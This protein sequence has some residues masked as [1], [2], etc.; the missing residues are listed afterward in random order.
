[1]ARS[2]T[3]WTCSLAG[4]SRCPDTT[5]RFDEANREPVQGLNEIALELLDRC[6]RPDRYDHLLHG[7]GGAR[8]DAKRW[9]M[10]ELPVARTDRR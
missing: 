7:V 5:L 2:T 6:E 3:R 1:M 10:L 4:A 9:P 8:D